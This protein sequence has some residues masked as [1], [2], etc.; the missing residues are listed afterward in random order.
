VGAAISMTL[1]ADLPELGN[2]DRK[3]RRQPGEAP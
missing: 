1:L 2:L 3:G